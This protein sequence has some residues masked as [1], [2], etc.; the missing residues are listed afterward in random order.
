[1]EWWARACVLWGGVRA[2][3]W[4]ECHGVVVAWL[5]VCVTEGGDG[6]SVTNGVAIMGV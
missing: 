2:C 5:G 6:R 1:M 4:D 3:I